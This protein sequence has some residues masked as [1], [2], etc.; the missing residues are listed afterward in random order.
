VICARFP[1]DND[2]IRGFWTR[3]TDTEVVL[4]SADLTVHA[5]VFFCVRRDGGV[6][7]WNMTVLCS[8]KSLVFAT[9]QA[10]RAAAEVELLE[11]RER[12][13]RLFA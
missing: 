9:E 11:V 13:G 12:L 4:R 5:K 2:L 6:P 10:A 8:G 3:T 1:A 7:A